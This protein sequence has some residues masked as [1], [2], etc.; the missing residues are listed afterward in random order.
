MVFDLPNKNRTVLDGG[1]DYYI[2][3]NVKIVQK[4]Q[5]L[6]V[7]LIE[8]VALIKIVKDSNGPNLVCDDHELVV[9]LLDV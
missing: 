2:L 8:R 7:N 9:Q 3:V 1:G 5:V 6:G 4:A